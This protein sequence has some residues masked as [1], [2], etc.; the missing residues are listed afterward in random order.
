MDSLATLLMSTDVVGDNEK[1][2]RTKVS[3]TGMLT[4][5]QPSVK[6]SAENHI[7]SSGSKK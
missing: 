4:L 1:A 5:S 2:L 7:G 6:A 3:D